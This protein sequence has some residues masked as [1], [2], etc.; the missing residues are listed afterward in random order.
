MS[1]K[2]ED[3][4]VGFTFIYTANNSPREHLHI[5][6]AVKCEGLEPDEC[7]VVNFT[8]SKGGE[9]ALTY[10]KGDH[11]YLT[12][13]SDINFGDAEIM[14]RTFIA[15]HVNGTDGLAA[16]E[17]IGIEMVRQIGHK[18]KNHPA[19]MKKIKKVLAKKFLI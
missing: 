13:P 12:K 8:E 1:L 9:M 16:H 10:Q 14:T 6:L 7:I 19:V 4:K 15:D 17:P 2:P 18:G 11:P 5:V 3:I